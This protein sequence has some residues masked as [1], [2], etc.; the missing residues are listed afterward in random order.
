MV[1]ERR[2]ASIL[3]TS[4]RSCKEPINP[5][6]HQAKRYPRNPSL[7]RP[8][9]DHRLAFEDVLAIFLELLHALHVT[10]ARKTNKGSAA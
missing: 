1:I 4:F 10:V 5:H 2:F 6:P 8:H 7:P 9:P 3:F